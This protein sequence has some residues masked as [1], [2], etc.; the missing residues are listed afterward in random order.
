MCPLF[1]INK[2]KHKRYAKRKPQNLTMC[3][4][5]S[6]LIVFIRQSQLIVFIRQSELIGNTTCNFSLTEL[7]LFIRY[8][9]VFI[10]YN[11]M[12]SHKT[13]FNAD[14]M[15]RYT[16]AKAKPDDKFRAVC[17][18]CDS[19]FSIS[20]RGEGALQ[21]HQDTKKHKE[22]VCAAAKSLPISQ[23]FKSTFQ[24]HVSLS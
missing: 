16:W 4:R 6:Q 1:I 20:N 3:M 5:Q 22:A 8:F 23:H 17:T 18:L 9:K 24:F 11:K 13:S 15:I 12:P 19:D 10:S 2:L 14:W 7:R 21:Q